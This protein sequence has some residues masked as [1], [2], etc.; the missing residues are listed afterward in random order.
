MH[1]DLLKEFGGGTESQH[2]DGCPPGFPEFARPVV[3][4]LHH[5][6]HW[7]RRGPRVAHRNGDAKLRDQC[8]HLLR[9][10]SLT[11][12][13]KSRLFLA[14]MARVTEECLGRVV[15][16]HALGPRRAQV[17][18]DAT[19]GLEML[20]GSLSHE[21]MEKLPEKYTLRCG[22]QV[23]LSSNEEIPRGTCDSRG[24]WR[25]W[26]ASLSCHTFASLS[27]SRL[28]S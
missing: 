6:G 25:P 19:T 12:G 22:T 7:D 28:K 15:G 16:P 1:Q 11:R 20:C 4:N 9:A 17:H 13:C 3:V 23:A 24:T 26:V 14:E 27:V 21:V 5:R 18:R 10:L 2:P 8:E